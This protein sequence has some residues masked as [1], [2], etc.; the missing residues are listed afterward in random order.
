MSR[1]TPPWLTAPLL[2]S[3]LL[4]SP[5]ASSSGSAARLKC[6]SECLLPPASQQTLK[7]RRPDKACFPPQTKLRKTKPLPK[8]LINSNTCTVPE[9]LAADNTGDTWAA[10]QLSNAPP[11]VDRSARRNT[12]KDGKTNQRERGEWQKESVWEKQRERERERKRE[13]ASVTEQEGRKRRG[14]RE[15]RE[16]WDREKWEREKQ[17]RVPTHFHWHNLKTFPW[18]FKDLKWHFNDPSQ[19]KLRTL[20]HRLGLIMELKMKQ[21]LFLFLY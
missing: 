20:L 15:E 14:V 19:P 6:I 17:K 8:N 16:R 12:E 5:L 9:H 13:T 1:V 21:Q 7:I 18:L 10:T 3:P 2:S 4:S 11:L